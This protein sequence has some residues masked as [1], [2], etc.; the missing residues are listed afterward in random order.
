MKTPK[1]TAQYHF[2]LAA[3]WYTQYAITLML[4]VYVTTCI[5]AVSVHCVP[6]YFEG[7]VHAN[8]LRFN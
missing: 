5:N 1:Q 2:H 4:L 3:T 6:K 8:G 7:P